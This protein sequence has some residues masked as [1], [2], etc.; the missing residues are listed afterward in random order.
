MQS[1][2]RQKTQVCTCQSSHPEMAN[3]PNVVNLYGD[4]FSRDAIGRVTFY[5]YR[6]ND[7]AYS[8]TYGADGDVAIVDSSSGWSW[9]R[10]ANNDWTVRNYFERWT[11]SAKDCSSVTVDE[12]GFKVTGANVEDM[13][14]PE[15]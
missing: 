10:M 8:V 12:M 1:S 11:V 3:Q 4:T 9:T 7:V 6:H 15:R 5:R 13:N 14:L 2:A